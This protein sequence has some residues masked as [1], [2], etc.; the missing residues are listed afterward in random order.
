M[1]TYR[2]LSSRDQQEKRFEEPQKGIPSYLWE[3]ILDWV[4]QFVWAFSPRLSRDTFRSQRV[5]RMQVAMRLSDPFDYSGIDAV[6]LSRFLNR[7]RRSSTMTLNVLDYMLGFE[8]SK[9]QA[10]ALQE[11]L[12]LGGSEWEVSEAPD[13]SGRRYE[14]TKRAIGPVKE[15]IEGVSDAQRAHHHLSLAWSRLAGRDPDPSSSYRESIRAVEAAAKP[16]VSPRRELTTLGSVIGEL[17]AKPELWEVTLEK[18]T[19]TDVAAMAATIWTSQ[20]DRHGTD[21]GTVPL[22]VSQAEADAAFYIA[23]ALVRLFAGGHVK[24]R[25]AG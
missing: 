7:L 5:K 20:L 19:T 11:L 12:T 1:S 21:D 13:G 14:L 8:A 9:S 25:G 3:P 2:P 23:L 10:V 17:R 24:R 16:I 22:S 18:A 15:A 4:K 6:Q